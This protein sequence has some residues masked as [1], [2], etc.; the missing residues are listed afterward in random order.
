MFNDTNLSNQVIANK[1]ILH[2][3]VSVYDRVWLSGM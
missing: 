1:Y 2:F 3:Q